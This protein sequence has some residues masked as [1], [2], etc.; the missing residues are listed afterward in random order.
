MTCFFQD[1][2]RYQ[3]KVGFVQGV[4]PYSLKLGD[5][6]TS[7]EHL[8]RVSKNVISDY[9]LLRTSQDTNNEIRACK[10]LDAFAQLACECVA[11]KKIGDNFLALGKVNCSYAYLNFVN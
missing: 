4:D 8:P 7:L 1:T 5:M 3:D 9:L 6:D 11:A 2:K 10:S